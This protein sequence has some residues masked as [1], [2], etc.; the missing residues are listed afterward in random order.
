[1]KRSLTIVIT[2]MLAACGGK[3]PGAASSPPRPAES[4]Q[5]YEALDARYNGDSRA[6][7]DG[8][9]E[10]AHD[11]PDSRAGRKARAILQADDGLLMLAVLGSVA[12]A[13]IP[14]FTRYQNKAKEAEARTALQM[15]YTAQSAYFAEKKRYCRTFKECGYEPLPDQK[16]ILFMTPKEMAL[17]PGSDDL[18]RTIVATEAREALLTANVKPRVEKKKFLVAAVANLDGDDIMDVWTIDETG[19][20][21]HVVSD[22]E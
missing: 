16:Y 17:A 8:L 10:L 20:L 19:N 1:M 3:K 13:A 9:L 7:Y 15:V 2:A 12:G 6:Y 18:M 21:V 11:D 14:N 4:K 5:Y 22:L